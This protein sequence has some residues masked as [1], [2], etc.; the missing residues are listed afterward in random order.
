METEQGRK[1]VETETTG[2]GEGGRMEE[3]KEGGGL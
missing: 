2:Q 1:A 3:R